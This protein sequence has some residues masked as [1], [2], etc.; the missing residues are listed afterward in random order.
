MVFPAAAA[1][2]AGWAELLSLQFHPMSS[3]KMFTDYL[4]FTYIIKKLSQ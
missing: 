3:G 1:A 2:L 4:L